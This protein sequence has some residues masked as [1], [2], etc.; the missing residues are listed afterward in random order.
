[1]YA[2]Q[3]LQKIFEYLIQPKA[4]EVG[5]GNKVQRFE[6]VKYLTYLAGFEQS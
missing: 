5:D 1:M 2:N 6:S 3:Y 4:G